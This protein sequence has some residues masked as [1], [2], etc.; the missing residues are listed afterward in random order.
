[1]KRETGYYWVQRITDA[2]GYT[3]WEVAYYEVLGDR[4]VW[5]LMWFNDLE[6][7]DNAFCEINETRIKDPDESC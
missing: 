4:N 3:E 1:M 2:A 6:F 5:T 7:Q